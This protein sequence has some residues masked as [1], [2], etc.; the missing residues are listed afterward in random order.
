MTDTNGFIGPYCTFIREEIA[1]KLFKHFTTIVKILK[2]MDIFDIYLFSGRKLRQ[3][4]QNCTE[5]L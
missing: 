2:I 5:L 4:D 3:M 1:K